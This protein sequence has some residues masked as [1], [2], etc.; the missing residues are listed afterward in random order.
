MLRRLYVDNYKSFVN[1][2]FTH[3]TVRKIDKVNQFCTDL[4]IEVLYKLQLFINDKGVFS[5]LFHVKTKNKFINTDIQKFILEI[6]DSV[7][8]YRYELFI[9]NRHLPILLKESLYLNDELLFEVTEYVEYNE[10]VT[11]YD[12]DRNK[13]TFKFRTERYTS[14]IACSNFGPKHNLIN[15]FKI[16]INNLILL[17]VNPDVIDGDIHKEDTNLNIDGSNFIA[18]Y[19]YIS[20]NQGII[21]DL[22]NYL[23]NDAIP[24]FI[25]CNIK[26]NSYNTLDVVLINNEGIKYSIDF[27]DLPDNHKVLFIYYTL[28]CYID[29]VENIDEIPLIILIENPHHYISEMDLI[30]IIK[31]LQTVL[32]PTN[33]IQVLLKLTNYNLDF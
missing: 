13:E 1:N 29:K 18:W 23:K 19:K 30:K 17:K 8:Y 26:S 20:N 21:T 27:N 11:I 2:D 5:N 24:D 4:T 7:G 16:A 3:S 6:Q 14:F 15:R 28:I 32:I 9:F 22:F 33:H 10:N 12:I 31:K 25:S